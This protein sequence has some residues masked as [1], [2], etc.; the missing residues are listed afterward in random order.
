MRVA[1]VEWPERLEPDSEAFER[2][3]AEISEAAPDVLVT[4]EMPFGVWLA[5]QPAFDRKAAQV[6]VDLHVRGLEALVNLGMPLVLSSRPVSAGEKLANEA[7]ALT[8]GQ[9]RP[10][11]RKCWFPAEPGWH[12]DAWFAPGDGTFEIADIDGLRVG[13][14]L[15]TELMFNEH[16]RAYG[17]AGADLIIAPRATG[18]TAMWRTAC[19]MAAYVS[20]AYVVSSNRS[21]RCGNAVFAGNGLAIAPDGNLIGMTTADNPLQVFDLDPQRAQAQKR[22][23]PCYIRE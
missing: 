16:A 23:Y 22:E 5:D 10:L 17:R 21:G 12:E 2:V 7:F 15:C 9:Y 13:V 8:K 20:G 14:L 1:C 11:H 6:S 4:N 18:N 19:T 3:C